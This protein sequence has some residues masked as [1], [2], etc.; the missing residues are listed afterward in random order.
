MMMKATL[1]GRVMPGTPSSSPRTTDNRGDSFTGTS[2][3]APRVT[4]ALAI[5]SQKCPKLSSEQLGFILL[6]SARDLGKPGV[7]EV[8]GYGLM[9]LE[10]AMARAKTL[11]AEFDRFDSTIPKTTN[12]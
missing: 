2:F 5:L 1:R 4:G 8:Y 12:P 9:D 11:A 7:D 10:N 6:R 3:A